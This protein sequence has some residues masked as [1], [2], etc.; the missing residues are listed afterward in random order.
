M[1]SERER[2]AERERDRE[3]ERRER[4]TENGEKEGWVKE[5]DCERKKCFKS[6]IHIKKTS[7]PNTVFLPYASVL[8]YE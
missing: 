6:S 2:K 1:R 8:E 5:N 7:W 4:E 3:R